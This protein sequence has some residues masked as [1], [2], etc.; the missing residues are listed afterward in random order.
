MQLIPFLT[1]LLP[2][3]LLVIFAIVT[4][5]ILLGKKAKAEIENAKLQKEEE[6]KNGARSKSGSFPHN[7]FLRSRTNKV[8]FGM[9]GGLAEY[10]NID[11]MLVRIGTVLL[12]VL[13]AV[14]P[15]VLAYIICG[16]IIPQEPEKESTKY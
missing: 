9:C 3:A 6:L 1:F 10:F 13:T 4:L 2:V 8:I 15:V 12:A 11:P 7:R 16:L 14:F 5:F